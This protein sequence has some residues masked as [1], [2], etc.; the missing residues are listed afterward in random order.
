MKTIIL[1]FT[2]LS[3]FASPVLAK[4]KIDVLYLKNEEVLKGKITKEVS[5]EYLMIKLKDG[6]TRGV[7]YSDIIK[8][9]TDYDTQKNNYYVSEKDKA[10]I[11]SMAGKHSGT[12][13]FLSLLVPSAGHAYA[14]KWGRG[15][16]F[17]AG[18]A[19][20]VILAYKVG[21]TKTEVS[22]R[23]GRYTKIGINSIYYIGFAS[24]LCLKIWE[25][26]DAANIVDKYNQGVWQNINL[27]VAPNVDGGINYTMQIKF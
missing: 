6:T 17:T 14:G 7:Q 21:I 26:C 16:L 25:V 5:G 24:A 1:I 15:L 9:E 27:G 8:R 18:E 11:Y 22:D 19:G 3:M 12:A 2:F 20:S 23:Y 4:D 13:V 10:I